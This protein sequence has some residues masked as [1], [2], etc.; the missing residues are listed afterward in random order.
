[1]IERYAQSGE[2]QILPLLEDN[3]HHRDPKGTP[4]DV[5]V[6]KNEMGRLVQIL[7]IGKSYKVTYNPPL[8]SKDGKLIVQASG[9]FQ[10][11]GGFFGL[12]HADIMY[13]D[14]SKAYGNLILG[15]ING[16]QISKMY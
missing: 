3:H 13:S 1:M 6:L 5:F 8:D 4:I 7:E 11:V 10:N 15:L 14:E 9:F 2:W 12:E 16:M